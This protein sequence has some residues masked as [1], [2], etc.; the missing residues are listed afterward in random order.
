MAI[1]CGLHKGTVDQS[2]YI[3]IPFKSHA[4]AES[5]RLHKV[6]VQGTLYNPPVVDRFHVLCPFSLQSDGFQ[7]AIQVDDDQLQANG[8]SI[9]DVIP[10]QINTNALL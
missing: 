10:F 3:Q 4:I 5:I 8:R 2:N 6:S 1:V 7:C 9:E